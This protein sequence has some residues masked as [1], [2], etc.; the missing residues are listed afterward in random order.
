MV[1]EMITKTASFSS[2]SILNGQ[3]LE[4]YLQ[5]SAPLDDL[6]RDARFDLYDYLDLTSLFSTFVDQ[7][8]IIHTGITVVYM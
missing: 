4:A 3:L 5:M 7:R 6:Y 8:F 2:M 1:T